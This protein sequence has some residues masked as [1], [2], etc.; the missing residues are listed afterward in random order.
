VDK[1]KGL[2]E[3]YDENKKCHHLN[4]ESDESELNK[5]KIPLWITI[6]NKYGYYVDNLPASTQ[7]ILDEAGVVQPNH[8]NKK[9]KSI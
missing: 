1:Y 9:F 3:E 7:K 8:L 5:L 6:M 2:I 4:L